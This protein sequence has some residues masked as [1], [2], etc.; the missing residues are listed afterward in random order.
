MTEAEPADS[1]D[2]GV[3]SV[4][5]NGEDHNEGSGKEKVQLQFGSFGKSEESGIASPL[6]RSLDQCK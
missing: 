1:T 3:V 5:A 2:G 4:H 6:R